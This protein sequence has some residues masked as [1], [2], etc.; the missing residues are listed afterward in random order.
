MTMSSVTVW[1]LL[2][3]LC[4]LLS[5]VADRHGDDDDQQQR[6]E[7]TVFRMGSGDEFINPNDCSDACPI[8]SSALSGVQC[9]C[10]CMA[11]WTWRQDVGECVFGSGL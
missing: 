8:G 6:N 2:T 1:P 3:A 4:L 9:V 7:Q 11:L 10:K 5:S